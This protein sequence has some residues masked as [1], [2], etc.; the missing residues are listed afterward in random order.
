MMENIRNTDSQIHFRIYNGITHI[1]TAE[2]EVRIA[3]FRAA[4]A[5][6]GLNET[7]SFL[8]RRA[9]LVGND[10]A[11]NMRTTNSKQADFHT[12]SSA[13]YRI[14]TIMDALATGA[15]TTPRASHARCKVHGMP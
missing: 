4:A 7:M 6:V 11:S 15:H 1:E 2:N 10:L 12:D 5:K 9:L 14:H 8:A 3:L 13:L